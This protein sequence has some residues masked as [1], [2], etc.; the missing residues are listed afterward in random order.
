MSP[1]KYSKMEWVKFGFESPNQINKRLLLT[2][3]L[4][5]QTKLLN[6]VAA[7]MSFSLKS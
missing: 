6:L 4:I 3:N 5:G 1:Q 7:I 2:R